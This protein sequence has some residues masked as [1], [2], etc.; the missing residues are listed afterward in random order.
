MTWRC[1]ADRTGSVREG[2]RDPGRTGRSGHRNAVN[3]IMVIVLC[4]LLA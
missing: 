1:C 3:D 2:I 4:D